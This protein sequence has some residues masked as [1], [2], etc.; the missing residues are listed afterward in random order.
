[1]TNAGIESRP[2]S[3]IGDTKK[4]PKAETLIPKTLVVGGVVQSKFVRLW[5][6][7]QVVRW[8]M[9]KE[10]FVCVVIYFNISMPT[11]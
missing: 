3:F 8:P 6:W 4:T 2:L 1:M 7:A 11:K 5:G 10:V 9:A